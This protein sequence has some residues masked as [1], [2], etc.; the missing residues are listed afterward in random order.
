MIARFFGVCYCELS[1]QEFSVFLFELLLC[2]MVSGV[3]WLAGFVSL[4]GR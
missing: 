1:Y 2:V 4:G 3:F